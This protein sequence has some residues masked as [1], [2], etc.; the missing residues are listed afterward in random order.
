[1]TVAAKEPRAA[2]KAAHWFREEL[3]ANGHPDAGIAQA[4]Y[5]ALLQEDY[6]RS[7]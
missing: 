1:M 5:G 3:S 4:E 2:T 6:K 7:F